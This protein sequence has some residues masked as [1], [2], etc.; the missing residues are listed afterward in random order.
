MARKTKQEAQATRCGILDAAERLFHAQGVSRTSLQDIAGA[1]GVTRGAIYW[2]F[3][4][5]SDLF[6]AM[7][8]RVVLPME[9]AS[10]GLDAD[11]GRPAL[12]ALRA[13]LLDVLARI[14][15]EASLRRVVEIAFHKV[16]HVGE[17]DA[18]RARR[19]QIRRDYRL[20]L[21]RALRRAQ[22]RGEVRPGLPA[23]QL[24]IGLHALLDGLLQNWLLDPAGFDLRKTGA[25]T[26]DVHL[27]GMAVP[28]APARPPTRR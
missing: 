14:T 16:E 23:P 25:G 6:N 15:R 27:A 20:R 2:H 13:L 18:V 7:M 5:K 22:A 3:K 11:D 24:A 28:A 9:E 21:E 19:V 4:D 17:L 1:A 8:D 10:A 12:P 26:I